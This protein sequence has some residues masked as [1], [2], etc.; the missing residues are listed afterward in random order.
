MELNAIVVSFVLGVVIFAACWPS[1]KTNQCEKVLLMML[2]NGAEI[3]V[4]S[5]WLDRARYPYR[6]RKIKIT[7]VARCSDIPA[8]DLRILKSIKEL[9]VFALHTRPAT[10]H[11]LILAQDGSSVLCAYNSVM[12]AWR[13]H[14]TLN[15]NFL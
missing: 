4:N 15:E 1:R 12:R 5:G 2:E 9:P 3:M 11:V 13:V 6:T 8:G 10:S 14:G 7:K